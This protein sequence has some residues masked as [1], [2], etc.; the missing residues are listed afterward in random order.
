MKRATETNA[1]FPPFNPPTHEG[2]PGRFCP[3]ET[4]GTNIT[5][6]PAAVSAMDGYAVRATDANKTPV[7][8]KRIGESSAGKGFRGKIA[9]TVEAFKD[10][11]ILVDQHRGPF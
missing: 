1:L 9:F 7:K 8:L 2:A 11:R 10:R 5:H 6:P 4:G 3:G